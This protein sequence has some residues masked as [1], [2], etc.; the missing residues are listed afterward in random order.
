MDIVAEQLVYGSFPFREG[1]YD[2]L[3][4]SPGCTPG[5]TAEVVAVCRRF[6]QPPSSEAARPALFALPLPSGP[7]AVVGVSPQGEDDR[8]R[9]GAL[10]FHALIVTA[11]D[12]LKA[13]SSPFNFAQSHRSDWSSAT[14][15]MLEPVRCQVEPMPPPTGIAA[16][17]RMVRI[18]AALRGKK[19]VA[20]ESSG[21]VADLARSTWCELAPRIRRRLSVAT[22]AFSSE[23]RFDLVAFPRLTG[24]ALDPSYVFP[25]APVAAPPAPKPRPAYRDIRD[26]GS[27][28]VAWIGL[29]VVVAL[30]VGWSY[31]RGWFQG[32][33]RPV[34]ARF[35][36][37]P[38]PEPVAVELGPVETK[39]VQVGLEALAS[40]FEGGEIGPASDPT[41]LLTRLNEAYHYRGRLL[42]NTDLEALGRELDPETIRVL[43]WHAR[44][45]R[46]L[47]DEAWPGNFSTLPLPRQLVAVARSFHLDP[48]L[49]PTEIP[50]ALIALIARPGVIQPTPLA[51]R[52][53][54]LSDYA[55]FLS[56]LPRSDDPSGSESGR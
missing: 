24:V 35:E 13:G 54:A 10:A 40:R 56:K 37:R 50:G 48:A 1:G 45:T 11:R 16:D 5:L 47:P 27:V 25:D 3:A 44:I 2:L 12:Y 30:T 21:P 34:A 26:P 46:F 38:E 4:R 33:T 42:S 51:A 53:P 22:W 7:W 9:P 41:Q 55:R 15:G 14:P 8:G 39:R 17:P 43:A 20:L 6:G 32:Q 36:A 19:R 28:V 18:V 23:N 49:G 29:V 31:S 52:F